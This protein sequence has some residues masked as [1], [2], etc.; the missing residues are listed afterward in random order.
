MKRVECIP[1]LPSPLHRAVRFPGVWRGAS[2]TMSRRIHTDTHAY[3]TY[4][5]SIEKSCVTSTAYRDSTR[6]REALAKGHSVSC[7][8]EA[9]ESIWQAVLSASC[10]M[11]SAVQ[12]RWPSVSPFATC[13]GRCVLNSQHCDSIQTSLCFIKCV[14]EHLC[15]YKAGPLHCSGPALISTGTSMSPRVCR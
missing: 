10:H 2:F 6:L 1:Q 3:L 7:V 14:D 13:S 8:S 9:P 11:T 12:L 5:L 15:W 4:H